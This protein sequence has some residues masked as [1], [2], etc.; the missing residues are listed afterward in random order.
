MPYAHV[1][2][3]ELFF[4]DSAEHDPAA[5]KLPAV[6]FSHG[7]L[8]DHSMFTDQVDALADRWR[9]IAW[10]ERGHGRTNHGRVPDPFTYWD[11]ADDAAALLTHLGITRAVFAGM[12]QGG[13]LSLRAAL[14]Y[15]DM[16]RGLILLD[17]QAGAEDAEAQARNAMFVQ[18]W[19]EQGMNDFLLDSAEQIIIGPGYERIAH[20]RHYW[21]HF[22]AANFAA[23]TETLHGREDLTPRLHDIHIPSLVVHGDADVAIPLSKGQALADG[24]RGRLVVVPG[25]G[26]AANM[27]HADAVNQAIIHFLGGLPA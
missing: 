22:P 12:S 2:G 23:C 21:R 3:Q 1:N 13:F 24:L 11:S 20:W 26:H 4:Q 5:Q 8:M 14:R 27:T 25:A 9:C 7:L 15:P 10:D 6:I 16:V 17:T 19:V 18:M